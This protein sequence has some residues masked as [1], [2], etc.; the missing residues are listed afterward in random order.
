MKLSA[1]VR[2]TFINKTNLSQVCG[3]NLFAA[4]NTTIAVKQ[5]Q[6]YLCLSVCAVFFGEKQTYSITIV[7]ILHFRHSK[8]YTICFWVK[9]DS[10]IT[11]QLL[12]ITATRFLVFWTKQHSVLSTYL[13][14]SHRKIVSSFNNLCRSFYLKLWSPNL[15]IPSFERWRNSTEVGD[16]QDKNPVLFHIIHTFMLWDSRGNLQST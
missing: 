8:Y 12:F 2:L 10:S 13:R 4:L 14:C 5:R 3:F 1:V 15:L 6:S 7:T 9:C 16:T 11:L